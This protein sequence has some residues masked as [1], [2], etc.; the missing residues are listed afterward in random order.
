MLLQATDAYS[1][2]VPGEWDDMHLEPRL[3]TLASFVG[4]FPLMGLCQ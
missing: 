2:R 3:S 1:G 4:S